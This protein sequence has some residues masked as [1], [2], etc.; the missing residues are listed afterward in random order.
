MEKN[1]SEYG[2]PQDDH[3]RNSNS[4]RKLIRHVC[5]C[6]VKKYSFKKFKSAKLY[7]SGKIMD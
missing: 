3:L 6:L 7:T 2:W 5:P 4:Q 1:E